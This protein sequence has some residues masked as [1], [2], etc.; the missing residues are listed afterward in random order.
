[1]REA[2]DMLNN[3]PGGMVLS[4]EQQKQKKAMEKQYANAIIALVRPGP[5]PFAALS[6]EIAQV[7]QP[8]EGSDAANTIPRQSGGI[9]AAVSRVAADSSARRNLP[10]F[11]DRQA[12]GAQEDDSDGNGDV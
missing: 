7:G 3:L 9:G 8:L 11:N 5:D 6:A 2:I 1:M 12:R 10:F 4:A